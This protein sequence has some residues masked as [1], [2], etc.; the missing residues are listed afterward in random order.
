M[1]IIYT[2]LQHQ[3]NGSMGDVPVVIMMQNDSEVADGKITTSLVQQ[4][5]TGGARDV[6]VVIAVNADGTPIASGVDGL[7]G[8]D[9]ERGPEG[10]RGQDGRNLKIR[11]R[12]S[13]DT[14]LPTTGNTDGDAFVVGDSTSELTYIWYDGEWLGTGIQQGPEGPRGRDGINGRD[15]V[16]G[17]DGLNGSQGIPG[18]KGDPGVDGSNNPNVYQRNN[19]IG[20]V[21]QAS[22]VPTGALIGS[23]SNTSGRYIKYADGTMICWRMFA[24]TQ[25]TNRA[26]GAVFQSDVVN[27]TFPQ[28]FASKPVMNPCSEFVAGIVGWGWGDSKTTSTGEL[29][30]ISGANNAQG[31]VGYIAIGRWY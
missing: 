16:D 24:T 30:L 21:S 3:S 4:P 26:S 11:G 25:T 15:G 9:G 7:P 23:G 10:P 5:A 27:V 28:E 6:H 1:T 19:I 22:G 29:R 13:S 12:L 20:P 2:D 18:V 8:K 17:K 31:K 14:M